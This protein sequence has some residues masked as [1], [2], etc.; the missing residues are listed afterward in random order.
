MAKRPDV[1][2]LDVHNCLHAHPAARQVLHE[3]GIEQA[4]QF[5]ADHVRRQRGR[6]LLCCDGGPQGKQQTIW[7]HQQQWLL[8]GTSSADDVIVAYVRKHAHQ[9]VLVVTNDRE[10][11]AR[12][13]ACGAFV[14]TL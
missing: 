9:R 5:V 2:L 8:S 13:R 11:R 7:R 12:V 6:T 1:V 4:R 10:L 3:Q 14:A